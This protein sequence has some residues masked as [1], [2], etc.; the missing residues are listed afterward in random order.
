MTHNGGMNI[1]QNTAVSL[2]FDHD[3]EV[4]SQIFLI[5]AVTGQVEPPPED[6]LT[7]RDM[8]I[9]EIMALL[10][11]DPW[12]QAEREPEEPYYSESDQNFFADRAENR[13]YRERD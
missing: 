8:E 1:H 5:G 11:P 2:D 3:R 7:E 4:Q 9:A 6:V 10:V 13:E 12:G